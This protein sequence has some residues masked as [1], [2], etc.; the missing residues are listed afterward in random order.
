LQQ[1]APREVPT[2][3]REG[4]LTT[5]RSAAHQTNEQPVTK[6]NIITFLGDLLAHSSLRQ[7]TALGGM[8]AVWIVILALN[9]AT[10]ASQ[11]PRVAQTKPQPLTPETIEVLKQQRLLYAELVDPAKRMLVQPPAPALPGPRSQRR[12]ETFTV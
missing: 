3:W 11:S 2:A 10:N 6:H 1:I 12:E 7:R 8:A 5:A 4:I 9:L